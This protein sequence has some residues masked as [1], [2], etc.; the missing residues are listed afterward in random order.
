[1][2]STFNRFG[3]HDDIFRS[4]DGGRS[5]APVIAGATF[6]HD[7]APWTAHASPHWIADVQID[8]FDP[9]RVLFVTGYG[10]WASRDIRAADYGQPVQLCFQN[11][12][13]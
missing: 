3:P 6:E 1:M 10:L 7:N 5:W 12:G 4:T 9:R 2:A 11:D 8:P 13:L